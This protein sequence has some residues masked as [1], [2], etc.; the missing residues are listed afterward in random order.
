[1][2]YASDMAEQDAC[3]HHTMSQPPEVRK[4]LPSLNVIAGASMDYDQRALSARC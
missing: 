2:S 3:T 4:I 1:M